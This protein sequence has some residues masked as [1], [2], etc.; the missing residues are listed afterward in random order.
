MTL[1]RL[2]SSTTPLLRRLGN[3]LLLLLWL[4]SSQGIAPGLVVAAARMDGGHAVKVAATSSGEVTV[5]LAHEGGELHGN[6]TA[7]HDPLTAC[8]VAFSRQ[9]GPE[10]EDHVL[11][12]MS[13]DS[14]L[15]LLRLQTGGAHTALK[16]IPPVQPVQVSLF[17]ITQAPASLPARICA[18]AWSPG[19]EIK[20]CRVILR[21]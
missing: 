2:R 4:L 6:A 14:A 8:L 17:S 21:C 7:E 10:D 18:P 13:L 11:S 15:K 16:I 19:R 3:G 12:F 5:V 9:N 20:A 1:P